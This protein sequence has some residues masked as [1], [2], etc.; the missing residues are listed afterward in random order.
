MMRAL[1]AAI[2]GTGFMGDAHVEA[3]RRLGV[4]ISGILGSD[5]QKGQRAR[6][7]LDLPKVYTT[8]EE[9]CSD[10]EVDVVHLCTPNYL[11][12]PMAKAVLSA[13]KHVICEKPLTNTA[14]EAKELVDLAQSCR[15]V[16]AVNYN[17]RYYPLC[18]EAHARLRGG[19]IGEVRLMHGEYCQDWLFSVND[20]NWRL[21]PELGG[22]LRV[23]ADVGTHWLDMV[24]W[25][26][27]LE[28]TAVLADFATFIPVRHKPHIEVETFA[29]K[30]SQSDDFDEVSVN[31]EDYAGLLVKFNNG[32]RAVAT[33]SQ[34]NAGRKNHFFWEINGSLASMW[35]DQENPNELWIGH[36]DQPNEMV[37]KDPALMQAEAR[38]YA[39]YPGGHAEGYP[40]THM[41]LFKT[42]YETIALGDFNQIPSYPT[43]EDGWRELVLCEAIQKSAVEG[44]WVDI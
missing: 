15:R 18:Q 14:A 13:G 11:H 23:V 16:A 43:F 3:L 24:T 22:S 44:C 35:W 21:I 42:V 36:R 26:T 10:A 28:V 38:S 31:T 7:K 39:G 9:I 25:L 8:I 34:I 33:F 37:I 29:S 41:R 27:G 17:L 5:P 32:A 12:H 40:D 4:K 1:C 19:Q 30:L 20:W 2:A 6:N